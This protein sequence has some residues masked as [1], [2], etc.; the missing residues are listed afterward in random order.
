MVE[1]SSNKNELEKLV[2]FVK[3]KRDSRELKRA[4]AVKLC[5]ENYSYRQIQSI[6]DVSIGFI[7]KW[8]KIFLTQGVKGLR[9]GHKGA[10]PFLN[11]QE[12]AA[13]I[14]YLKTKDDWNL[15]ELPPLPEGQ[16]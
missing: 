3:E 5:L 6:V 10:K 13:V 14:N 8:K 1:N 12:K 2:A 4:L 15:R 7:S 9:L 16:L 11:H